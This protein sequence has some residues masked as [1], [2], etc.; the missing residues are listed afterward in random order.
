MQLFLIIILLLI[1]FFLIVMAVDCNRF[2][3]KEYTYE[4]SKLSKDGTFLLLSDLH[5]KNFGPD[6]TRLMQ[7]IDK[8]KPDV[9]VMAG[10]MYTASRTQDNS[11]ITDFVC[12]LAAKYP[13]YCGNGNHEHKTRLYPEYYGNCYEAYRN[14]LKQ[15]GAVVLVNEKCELPDYNICMY[16]LEIGHSY[17]K[18]FVCPPMEAS[19]LQKTLG[20][21]KEQMLNFL[22]A[23]NPDFFESY[24]DWGADLV[25]SGH[26][27]GGLM[28]LPVLGGV[29]SPRLLL[30]PHYDGGRFTSGKSTMLLGR[31]LGTHTL[32]I[33]IFN[34]GEL[35]VIHMRKVD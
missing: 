34:P 15:A 32:P 1:L 21:P 18:K 24:A 7:A 12:R 17:Y 5:N 19:Y 9:I 14:K 22:I 16:G 23:H 2:V 31:G 8:Q 13:V 20:R 35:V 11:H 33:R 3:I 6:N 29:I 27:H 30:F 25:V 26:I 28:R 4:S 10:D